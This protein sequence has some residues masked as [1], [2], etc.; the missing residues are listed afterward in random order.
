M[1]QAALSDVMMM[2]FNVFQLIQ[3]KPLDAALLRRSLEILHKNIKS[4]S[5]RT[6]LIFIIFYR[7]VYQRCTRV[8]HKRDACLESM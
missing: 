1:H 7:D 8:S 5:V 4:K 6:E 3:L 2:H